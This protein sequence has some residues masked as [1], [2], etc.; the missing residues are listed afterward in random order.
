[1]ILEGLVR[2]VKWSLSLEG[3]F[4]A[5]TGARNGLFSAGF[6]GLY[7]GF[8]TLKMPYSNATFQSAGLQH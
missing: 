8:S 7:I 6:L 5:E 2:K 4:Y 1:V 3:D